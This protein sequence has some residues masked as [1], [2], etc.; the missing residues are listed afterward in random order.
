M[1]KRN[2]AYVGVKYNVN[3][4]KVALGV[5]RPT[6]GIG[7]TALETPNLQATLACQSNRPNA[8]RKKSLG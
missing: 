4:K 6:A 2:Y 5:T 3:E 7:N 8:A 1:E